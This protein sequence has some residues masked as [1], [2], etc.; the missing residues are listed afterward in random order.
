MVI[1]SLFFLAVGAIGWGLA[2][3]SY[4]PLATAGGWPLGR[5]QA[6][7]PELAIATG[8]FSILA[9]LIYALSQ[10]LFTGGLVVLLFAVGLAVFWTGFLRVGAQSALLL[11]PVAAAGLLLSWLSGALIG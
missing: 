8:F 9:G 7:L 2:L 11:A 6:L 1:D 3:V 10:G 5:V 4:R